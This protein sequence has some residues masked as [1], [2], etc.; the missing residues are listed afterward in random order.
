ML[1]ARVRPSPDSGSSLNRLGIRKIKPPLTIGSGS[2]PCVYHF[3][4][5]MMWFHS[6]FCPK[7]NTFRQHQGFVIFFITDWTSQSGIPCLSCI[8]RERWGSFYILGNDH[9]FFFKRCQKLR[10]VMNIGECHF[11]SYVYRLYRFLCRLLRLETK[12]FRVNF[13]G[14]LFCKCQTALCTIQPF[15][16]IIRLQ[17]FPRHR[18]RH[19]PVWQD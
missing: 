11:L 10:Y 14:A 12:V 1:P 9:T 2:I 5:S 15:N 18:S 8:Q 3:G 16:R 7:N 17:S 13:L 4:F 19:P 6:F